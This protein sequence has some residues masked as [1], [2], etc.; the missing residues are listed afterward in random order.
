MRVMP[1][2][3]YDDLK[4]LFAQYVDTKGHI[5][6]KVVTM[7]IK[8]IRPKQN[9]FPSDKTIYNWYYMLIGTKKRVNNNGRK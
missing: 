3:E 2:Y 4:D 9:R 6:L 1:N 8:E 7:F 5:G